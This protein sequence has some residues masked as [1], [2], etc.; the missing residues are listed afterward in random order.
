MKRQVLTLT[1]RYL[2][3]RRRILN[4]AI[5]VSTMM[6]SSLTKVIERAW[7]QMR[8]KGLWG[9]VPVLVEQMIGTDRR[10]LMAEVVART[11]CRQVTQQIRFIART[12]QNALTDSQS[13]YYSYCSS[14]G[15]NPIT[16]H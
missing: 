6:G 14:G 15:L 1:L 11:A 7:Q 2:R 3:E 12:S 8:R 16:F 10:C 5:M 13:H 4:W 9:Q